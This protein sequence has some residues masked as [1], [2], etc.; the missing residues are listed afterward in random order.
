ME[1]CTIEGDFLQKPA[2]A[3]IGIHHIVEAV[4]L[5]KME[6]RANRIAPLLDQE[7]YEGTFKR[8]LNVHSMP[9]L[10]GLIK[11]FNH[12]INNLIPPYQ[13]ITNA[14]V[15][16]LDNTINTLLLSYHGKKRKSGSDAVNHPLLCTLL[17][18]AIGLPQHAIRKCARHDIAE[19][20]D[21]PDGITYVYFGLGDSEAAIRS[22][23]LEEI[24]AH[25]RQMEGKD[26]EEHLRLM[27]R[28]PHQRNFD[29]DLELKWGYGRYLVPIYRNIW[30]AFAKGIDAVANLWE[31]EPIN[32]KELREKLARKSRIKV[33]LQIPRWQKISWLMAEIMVVELG[34]HFPEEAY[35]LRTP[36]RDEVEKFKRGYAWV[37]FERTFSLPVLKRTGIAGSPIISFYGKHPYFEAEFPYLNSLISTTILQEV[38]GKK[39]R[40]IRL[41]ESLLPYN[42]RNATIISFE[43]DE[44]GLKSRIAQLVE[45][46]DLSIR[47]NVL[48]S[49]DRK[50]IAEATEAE[51]NSK[52]IDT[53]LLKNEGDHGLSKY[54]EVEMRKAWSV[55]T[56]SNRRRGFGSIQPLQA[57]PL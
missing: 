53:P 34:Y 12:P 23:N 15:E 1:N 11:I 52:G 9:L 21:S 50:S 47:E 27:T 57:G 31:I 3:D 29:G 36:K 6:W 42:L 43:A 18:S 35:F 7:W 13:K 17:A 26:A 10:L 32:D 2:N 33:S 55:Q 5:P 37:G 19:D 44:S 54:K 39:V 46:Y 14:D 4:R 56:A 25:I 51:I 28:L 48:A 38:L 30:A 40:N 22:K 8:I 16:M 41:S 24:F 45:A 20:A 49:F